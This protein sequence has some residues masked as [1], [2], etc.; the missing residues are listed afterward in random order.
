M[1]V[2]AETIK[3]IT[4]IK[5]V[6]EETS[7]TIHEAVSREAT[8]VIMS[9]QIKTIETTTTRGRIATDNTTI[10]TRRSVM[11]MQISKQQIEATMLRCLVIMKAVITQTM[12]G[13]E[14]PLA[15]L[16]TTIKEIIEQASMRDN[17]N[18]TALKE[19]ASSIIENH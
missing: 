15:A 10:I 9:T 7:R 4:S 3:A 17:T 11:T 8:K 18:V 2:T 5:T 13:I 19:A 14:M 6:T 16:I 12:I 1:Q